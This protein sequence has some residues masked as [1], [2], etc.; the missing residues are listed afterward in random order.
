MPDDLYTTDVVLWSERQA[1]ALRPLR[2]GERVNDLEWDNIIE[3]VESLG[4]SETRDVRTL[5]VRA[6]E[7]LL[8]AAAW[9]AAAGAP[10]W[11]HEAGVFLRGARAD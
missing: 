4:R 2:A 8:R 9:P 5:R 7:H 6:V 10:R 3:E 11:C 1:D